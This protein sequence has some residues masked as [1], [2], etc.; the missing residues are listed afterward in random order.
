MKTIMNMTLHCTSSFFK[1]GNLKSDLI[2]ADMNV[3]LHKG[4]FPDLQM[5]N[6]DRE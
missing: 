4:A 6:T 5:R 3:A 1:S 2:T